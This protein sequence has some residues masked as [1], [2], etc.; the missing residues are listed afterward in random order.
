MQKR[1]TLAAVCILV[2]LLA[3]D[4]F[5]Q[6]GKWCRGSGGWGLGSK[7]CRWYNP[8]TTETIR[9]EVLNI[10]TFSPMRGMS[11]GLQLKVKTDK[12]TIMVHLGPLWY[13]QNQDVGINPGDRIDLTGSR[14]G[15]DNQQQ[16]IIAAEVKRGDDFL[17]LRDKNGLPLWNAWSTP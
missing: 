17:K 3:G 9:G 10:T 12:E 11:N 13:L 5:A 2:F 1:I 8:K 16:C 6:R 14:V 4:C 15:L 7:Y